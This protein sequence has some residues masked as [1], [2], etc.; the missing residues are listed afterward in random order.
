[1][2]KAEQ[3]GKPACTVKVTAVRDSGGMSSKNTYW[4]SKSHADQVILAGLTLALRAEG[5]EVSVQM[6][7]SA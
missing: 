1:M 3:H 2:C 5:F 4:L 7:N 6:E